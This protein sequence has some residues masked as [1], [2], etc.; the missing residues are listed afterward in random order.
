MSSKDFRDFFSPSTF[1]PAALR[2][3]TIILLKSW[4][5]L[6]KSKAGLGGIKPTP[7]WGFQKVGAKC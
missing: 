2:G 5:K 1:L 4:R 3:L 7:T 6:F